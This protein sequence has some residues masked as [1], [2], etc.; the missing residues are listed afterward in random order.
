[1]WPGDW[2]PFGKGRIWPSLDQQRPS[3]LFDMFC[4]PL[5][6]LGVA[7]CRQVCLAPVLFRLMYAAVCRFACERVE[8]VHAALPSGVAVRLR[9]SPHVR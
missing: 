9:E 6:C 2:T 7:A 3:G 4:L 5:V 1:M 8:A